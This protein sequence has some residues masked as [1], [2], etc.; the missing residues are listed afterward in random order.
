MERVRSF[1]LGSGP[2]AFFEISLSHGN[3]CQVKIAG[4][5]W[6]V[7][8]GKRHKGSVSVEIRD[9]KEGEGVCFVLDTV[10]GQR[11]AGSL[12][13]RA[14]RRGSGYRKRELDLLTIIPNN[15]FSAE[16]STTG[17]KFPCLRV[18]SRVPCLLHVKPWPRKHT[19]INSAA[20]NLLSH[21]YHNAFFVPHHQQS[22]S[23]S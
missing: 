2:Q 11:R 9:T 21:F 18:T 23:N 8:H 3:S 12:C 10:I 1:Y 20:R 16:G 14:G 17:L 19:C 13:G 5:G 22:T 6:H 4:S 15:Q 7:S